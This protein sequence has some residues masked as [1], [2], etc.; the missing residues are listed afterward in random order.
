ML[1]YA[2]GAAKPLSIVVE[3]HGQICTLSSST[4]A[5]IEIDSLFDGIDYSCSLSRALFEELTK[6]TMDHFRNSM[7]PVERYTRDSGIDKKN[8][9]ES[10]HRVPELPFILLHGRVQPPA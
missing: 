10:N 4:Q 6:L 2:I 5:T 9:H 1:S 3:A 7:G 8:V